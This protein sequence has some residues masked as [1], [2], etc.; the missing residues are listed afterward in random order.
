M[1]SKTRFNGIYDKRTINFLKENRIFDFSL[2]FRAR[3]LNFIQTYRACE[4]L[5]GLDLFAVTMEFQNEKDFVI[6]KIISDLEEHHSG[7]KLILEFS[8]NE[9]A[10]FFDSFKRPYNL[11]INDSSK[12]R[13]DY[14]CGEYLS[15]VVFD[16]DFLSLLHRNGALSSTIGHYFSLIKGKSLSINHLLYKQWNLDVFP[17]MTEYLD[18]D[19][20]CVPIDSNIESCF[21]NVDLNRVKQELKHLCNL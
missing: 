16:G 7:D 3:S 15:G 19:T 18:F 17:T 21:R 10:Q 8:G 4:L 14:L 20:V 9:N 2:D 12:I 6:K 13:T 11:V 5:V 1:A